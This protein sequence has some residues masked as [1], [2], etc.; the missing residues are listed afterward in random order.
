MDFL[1]SFFLFYIFR[2][3]PKKESQTEIVV[4][5]PSVLFTSTS[6]NNIVNPTREEIPKSSSMNDIKSEYSSSRDIIMHCKKRNHA[7]ELKHK[8]RLFKK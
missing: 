2:E 5:P 3:V 6:K 4:P 1:K 7:E 8:G